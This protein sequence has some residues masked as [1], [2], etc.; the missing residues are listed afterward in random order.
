MNEI[1]YGPGRLIGVVILAVFVVGIGLL[2]AGYGVAVGLGA[3]VGLVLGFVAG[4]VGSLWLA[5]GPGRS[6]SFGGREW[7]SYSTGPDPEQ[8]GEMRDLAEISGVSLGAVRSVTP[9]LSTAE[10]AGLVVQLVTVE[11][12]EG[13][14]T[15]IL[16]VRPRPGTVSPGS[17]ARV[18][19]SDELGTRYRALA[20]SQGGSAGEIRYTLTVIP[21]P[22]AE[23]TRID[24]V[25]ERFMDAFPGRS[26][27]GTAG[28]WSF[29]VSPTRK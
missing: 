6:V 2:I 25:I 22:P 29:S 14:L 9:V 27:D 17:I 5:R 24:V 8:I 26:L 20:M 18:R 16:E 21:A 12:H 28:P 3:L 13:G 1:R 23:A 7:S 4:S 19:V 15:M 10:A 11:H